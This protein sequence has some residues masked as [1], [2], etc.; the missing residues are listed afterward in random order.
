MLVELIFMPEMDQIAM[1]QKVK[2]VTRRKDRARTCIVDGSAN[3]FDRFDSS[4]VRMYLISHSRTLSP[5]YLLYSSTMLDRSHPVNFRTT[6]TT[7][8]VRCYSNT[9][10]QSLDDG[11]NE[12][13]ALLY[14]PFH[15]CNE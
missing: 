1:T 7:Q 12:P 3:R 11:E 10:Q 15:G 6:A 5:A 13:S 8:P 14:R 9:C 4:K 2:M